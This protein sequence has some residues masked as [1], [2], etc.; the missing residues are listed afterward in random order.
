MTF[1]FQGQ[2]KLPIQNADVLNCILA[3]E[4]NTSPQFMLNSGS[5]DLIYW[6]E[7]Y[8]W[9][10]E[11]ILICSNLQRCFSKM[12]EEMDLYI[13][14]YFITVLKLRWAQEEKEKHVKHSWSP[15]CSICQSC[16][17]RRQENYPV[18]TFPKYLSIKGDYRSVNHEH[19]SSQ[20]KF[21]LDLY[22]TVECMHLNGASSFTESGTVDSIPRCTLRTW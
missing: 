21:I 16:N 17:T 3:T 9:K 2:P 22:L 14:K 11:W 6:S 5:L 4:P 10:F 15:H 19:S 12:V 18:V 1:T 7:Y 20:Q 13:T 8:F